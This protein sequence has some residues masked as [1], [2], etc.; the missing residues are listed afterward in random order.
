MEKAV[1][2]VKIAILAGH[3]WRKPEL[4]TL[5]ACMEY[6]KDEDVKR[7]R[8][9]WGCSSSGD[10]EESVLGGV[11]H[12]GNLNVLVWLRAWKT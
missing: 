11:I 1:K 9:L 5:A 6:L 2:M 3:P 8:S 10:G 4:V 7:R 12:G